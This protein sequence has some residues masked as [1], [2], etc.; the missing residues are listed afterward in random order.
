MAIYAFDFD[1]SLDY[2]VLQRLAIKLRKEKNEIWIVTA[3]RD[4]EYNR[5]AI[6]PV[7]DSL[8]LTHQNIIY[9]GNQPKYEM[10]QIINA[11]I[12][13]D[14]ITDEFENIINHTNTIPLLFN[15]L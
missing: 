3:R 1:G 11:D 12:Y 5:K 2:K 6:Q 15:Y 10:L 13:I 14:N 7:L 9:C 8:A 4:N